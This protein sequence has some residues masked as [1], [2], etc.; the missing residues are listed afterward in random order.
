MCS[1]CD[2]RGI[3]T[4]RSVQLAASVHPPASYNTTYL[5]AKT[6][7]PNGVRLPPQAAGPVH[8][9]GPNERRR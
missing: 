8:T 6:E 5:F 1:E 9:A 7:E 3:G 4:V 2:E